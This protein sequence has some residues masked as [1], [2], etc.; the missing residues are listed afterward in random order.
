MTNSRFHRAAPAILDEPLEAGVCA[1]PGCRAGA[2]HKAPKSRDE[3]DRY[4][5]FCL[6]HVRAYNAAWDYYAGMDESEI[7]AHR[8]QDVTWRRP[9]WPLGA[10][11]GRGEEGWGVLFEDPFGLLGELAGQGGAPMPKP[12][13]RSGAALDVLG[14]EAPVTADDVKARYIE[15]AKRLH[16]DANG[17][18]KTAEERLKLVNEAYATWKNDAGPLG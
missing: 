1:A 3:L 10:R 4:V 6:D 8:R 7:E 13:T 5:W 17:G 15:L 11:Q 9:T 16:P 2:S 12:R 14:L 18:D